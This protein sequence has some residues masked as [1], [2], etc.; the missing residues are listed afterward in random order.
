MSWSLDA[1]RLVP[2]ALAVAHLPCGSVAQS[3]PST[4]VNEQVEGGGDETSEPMGGSLETILVVGLAVLSIALVAGIALAARLRF[5]ARGKSVFSVT[6][7]VGKRAAYVPPVVDAVYR[8][9]L[10]WDSGALSSHASPSGGG[11]PPTPSRRQLRGQAS[12]SVMSM[13]S[14]ES[15]GVFVA[16]PVDFDR[17]AEHRASVRCEEK[18]RT[19][20]PTTAASTITGSGTP[21]TSPR[22]APSIP[23]SH[24]RELPSAAGRRAHGAPPYR[25]P[26]HPSSDRQSRGTAAGQVAQQHATSRER[27]VRARER[28]SPSDS[29]ASDDM[30]NPLDSRGMHAY[31][32]APIG[33]DLHRIET[34]IDHLES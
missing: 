23:P 9:A 15:G 17:V 12:D 20:T 22:T 6:S 11:G 19:R 10:I 33:P 5:R 24:Q 29:E 18:R 2:L 28:V 34:V 30:G 27:R 16:P 13:A 26:P 3:T 4:A 32:T 8:D 31:L 25:A 7:S 21:A 14:G 1:T